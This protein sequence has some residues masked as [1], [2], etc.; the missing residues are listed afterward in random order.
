VWEL[1]SGRELLT[2]EGHTGKVSAVVVTPDG[3]RAVSASWD[4][5]LKVWELESGHELRTLEG[6]ADLVNAVAVAPDGRWAI[7]ASDDNTLKVWELES[8]APIATFS[9]DAFAKCCA[10]ANDGTIVAGDAG[11]RLHILAL[12]R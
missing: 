5:T 11:G 1:K 12:E 2:L 6:H 4:G 10:V 8:C 3:R 7:S 9:C